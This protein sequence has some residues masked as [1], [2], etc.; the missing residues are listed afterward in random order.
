ML[1]RLIPARVRIIPTRVGSCTTTR[2]TT[3]ASTDHPHASGE[4]TLWFIFDQPDPGSSPREWG[5]APGPPRDARRRGIIPTRVG[6]CP[7]R[8]RRWRR[9]SD[10]P[11]ASGELERPAVQDPQDR[12]SSPR[13]WGAAPVLR[14]P[15]GQPRIIPTRVGSCSRGRPSTPASGDHPHASGEL[16]EG[17]LAVATYT[18]SSPREWGAGGPARGRG[19]GRG[20]IPTRV[21]S[22]D[23]WCGR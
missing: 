1:R 9:S 18:G 4:L 8:S 23:G 15:L 2:T 3:P 5:A 14:P 21:G 16:L 19:L 6:S 20:I 13:E 11:H 10:H 17:E 7:T 12:G 22:C